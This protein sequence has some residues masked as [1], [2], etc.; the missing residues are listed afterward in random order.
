MSDKIWMNCWNI[1]S[2]LTRVL[3][4]LNGLFNKIMLNQGFCNFN[5]NLFNALHISSDIWLIQPDI[6]PSICNSFFLI[7]IFPAFQSHQT[8]YR[9][10]PSKLLSDWIIFIS[11]REQFLLD[12]LRRCA[13]YS[14]G[15]QR[16]RIRKARE[17]YALARASGSRQ[18]LPARFN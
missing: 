16:G 14:C 11:S 1:W 15:S 8:I 7:T 9:N 10:M 2:K 5:W 4:N 13:N 18:Y 17:N 6:F 3:V 12:V